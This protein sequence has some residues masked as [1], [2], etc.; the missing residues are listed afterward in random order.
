MV[1]ATAVRHPNPLL[2][3]LRVAWLL[4]GDVASWLTPLFPGVATMRAADA[5]NPHG[6]GGSRYP[7]L[8]ALQ[9]PTTAQAH[10]NGA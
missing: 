7:V 3:R 2:T 8:N 9:F 4:N 6:L 1:E 10:G 5:F